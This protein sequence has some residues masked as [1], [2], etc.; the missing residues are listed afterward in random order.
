MY[1]IILIVLLVN[2]ILSL[3][4]RKDIL[5]CGIVAFSGKEGFNDDKIKLLL[6][7]NVER[8]KEGTGMWNEGKVIKDN[9]DA[10]E[11]LREHPI[12]PEPTFIGHTRMPSS[13]AYNKKEHAHPFKVGK[14]VSVHNGKIEMFFELL[15][16]IDLKWKDFDVD[17]EALT[18]LLNGSI[19]SNY[20]VLKDVKGKASIVWINEDE[21]NV[22]YAFR[23]NQERPLWRGN[24]PE[25]MYISSMD[26]SLKLIGCK[27]IEEF[28][29]HSIYK[30]ENGIVISN[31][32]IRDMTLAPD[33]PP[34]KSKF[35]YW[36]KQ[37]Q[38]NHH[39]SSMPTILDQENEDDYYGD[40]MGIHALNRPRTN[41]SLK[42]V[43][44]TKKSKVKFEGRDVNIF[45]WIQL[46]ED[47]SM[48]DEKGTRDFIEGK[49]VLIRGIYDES[50]IDIALSANTELSYLIP[51]DAIKKHFPIRQN[52]L[53]RIN[54][55]RLKE[56]NLDDVVYVRDIIED[57]SKVIIEK[58]P[59]EFDGYTYKIHLSSIRG[60][61]PSEISL[62]LRGKADETHIDNITD[63]MSVDKNRDKQ[64]ELL[65]SML[66]EAHDNKEKKITKEKL[67]LLKQE[68]END[69]IFQQY[70]Q[71][72]MAKD[73]QSAKHID[74]EDDSDEEGWE[75]NDQSLTEKEI[76]EISKKKIP[77][78]YFFANFLSGYDKIKEAES[79]ASIVGKAINIFVG[80][81]EFDVEA[82][83]LLQAKFAALIGLISEV[84]ETLDQG[85][86]KIGEEK[87]EY[88]D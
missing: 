38:H 72:A 73:M 48:I 27:D 10:K 57:E 85:I 78:K 37:N 11:F 29:I 74:D 3:F 71:K 4:S 26:E 7:D 14:I 49:E 19:N 13:F 88:K 77:A 59:E 50:S 61:E 18:A 42:V 12:I 30:I 32:N 58:T 28:A 44:E 40:A 34:K 25:G 67:K 69:E 81:E 54:T 41:A 24:R 33:K 1:S 35:A 16:K 79:K 53:A 5:Y 56:F 51:T 75:V 2:S 15:N 46:A 47:L 52:E 87:D 39:G 66:K 86:T 36:P 84:K 68:K 82:I 31:S 64:I 20:S 22:L 80:Q 76:D 45:D 23:K 21:P 70:Q 9:S 8:G 83:T 63:S 17:S 55:N 60:M 65:Q 43:K 62:Y 6:L